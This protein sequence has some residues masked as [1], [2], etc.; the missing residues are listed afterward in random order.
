MT[1]LQIKNHLPY[2]LF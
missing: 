1:T 2:F